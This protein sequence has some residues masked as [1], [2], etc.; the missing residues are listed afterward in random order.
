MLQRLTYAVRHPTD[1]E[2]EWADIVSDAQ[3]LNRPPLVTDDVHF[4]GIDHA[5][6][7][8]RARQRLDI[9]AHGRLSAPVLGA[10]PLGPRRRRSDLKRSPR[11][12]LAARRGCRRPLA[13]R[14]GGHLVVARSFVSGS[15][16]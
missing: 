13:A 3:R 2:D 11:H 12:L 1:T 14:T 6:L 15:I 4:K 10:P 5:A 8:P 7:S 16:G 9:V